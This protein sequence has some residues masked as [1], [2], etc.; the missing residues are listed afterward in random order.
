VA[1]VAAEAGPVSGQVFANWPAY[2][3]GPRHSSF[4]PGPAAITPANAA[5]LTARWT[6]RPQPKAGTSAYL[7][8]SPTTYNG[9]IYIGAF[10]GDFYAL[11]ESTGAVIWK[12]T[13]PALAS[14]CGSK[15]IDS[16]AAVAAD[17]VG[18]ALTVYVA[19]ADH[20]LYAL[21]PATGATR[22]R[23]LV[24]ATTSNYYN[25]SS[26][27][28]SAGRIFLG[29]GASCDAGNVGGVVGYDQHTGALLGTYQTA[30]GATAG[31]PTVYTSVLADGAGSVYAT[32]GDGTVGDAYSI[33]RLRDTDLARQDGWKI[34]NPSTDGD[35]NASPA[36]FDATVGGV[37]TSM[38]GACAKNGVYYA[39]RAGN[40]AAGPVW[41]RRVGIS[42]ALNLNKLRF[43][44]G[45]SAWDA[46]TKRLLLGANQTTATATKLG[47]AYS[48]DP[49]TGAV[50]WY[51][52]LAAGPVI[53]S[54][55][56]NGAGILA[57]PTY[58]AS[59]NTNAV[60]LLN[61]ATGAL[62]RTISTA[63]PDFA[64]PVFTDNYLLIT[65]QQ[66][67]TAYTP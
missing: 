15:G 53:G 39:W 11:N 62:L 7:N 38:V 61:E 9:V 30:P 20:Y 57:V 43:C 34:P 41:S 12:K 5:G 46:T 65:D 2:L 47:S 13:L 26:P 31:V 40:L 21:D 56:V 24:G 48:L 23:A 32:T 50:R 42:N 3:H 63:S 4:Q 64:Q 19:G 8:A 18:G 37:A 35:F 17:P 28:V 29:L 58:N 55:A 22:W 14:P 45:S 59:S 52:A 60:Y 1:G 10:T 27:T 54:V 36:F 67:L 33:V 44:G 16:T 66:K 25:W 51:R 6:W 49:A